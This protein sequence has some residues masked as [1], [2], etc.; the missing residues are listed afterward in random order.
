ML[1]INKERD[2]MKKNTVKLYVL[3]LLLMIILFIAL[4]VSNKINYM[5]LALIL[6]V[7]SIV[8]GLNF[9]REKILS[10]YK[11]QVDFLMVGFALIY[12]GIFYLLGLFI[13]NFSASPILLGFKSL[14][15]YII[16]LMVIIFSTEVIR[17]SLLS[18]DAKVRFF[19]FNVDLAK[20]ITFINMV[21][22]DLVIYSGVYDITNFN[23]FLTVVGFIFFASVSCNLFYNYVSTRYGKLGIIVY[24]LITVLYVYF[25]PVIPNMYIYFRSFLRMIYP[26][27]LY[28]ILEHTYSK[29]DFVVSYNDKKK[30]ILSITGLIIIMAL[31]TM[32]ISCQFKYGILVI[33]SDSMTGAINKGDAVIFESYDNQTIKKD[34]V[35]IF[36]KGS[37]RLVHRVIDI[38]N[39][40]GQLRYYTK[41]DANKEIDAGY[42]TYKDIIGISKFRIVYIG[43]PTIWVKELFS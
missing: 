19:K 28:L 34:Q 2:S 26:Y 10:T 25:I 20:P 39:V 1:A 21:L 5:I 41:G 3:E 22:V 24:R 23:E 11:K 31:I 29:T 38:K 14:Y 8:V 30:N 12:L 36:D 4:L 7:Y 37:I 40:N 33:G 43:Y 18:Q 32:L 42:V 16:P 35:I 9:K 15:R 27:L 17:F 6:F 13:Y